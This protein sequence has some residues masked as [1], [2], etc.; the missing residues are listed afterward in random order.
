MEGW[1]VHSIFNF[2]N[3]IQ[4][5]IICVDSF[6]VSI[7]SEQ[8]RILLND[9]I[10]KVSEDETSLVESAFELIVMKGGLERPQRLQ[11]RRAMDEEASE[12][13]ADQCVIIAKQMLKEERERNEHDDEEEDEDEEDEEDE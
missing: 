8:K 4:R 6:C 11:E 2:Y 5:A 1:Q 7:T 3:E 13:F 10:E 12:E 9:I